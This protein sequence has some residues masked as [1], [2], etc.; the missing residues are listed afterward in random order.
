MSDTITV[1]PSEISPL[2][3]D[4]CNTVSPGQ[5]P[6]YVNVI[7]ESYCQ[8]NFCF[9]NVE[10]KVQIDGGSIVYGWQ[11]WLMPEILIE[12]EF[13]AVWKSPQGELID[14]IPRSQPVEKILFI[15]DLERTYTGK[16]VDN[17][18][19]NISDNELVDTFINIAKCEFNIVSYFETFKSRYFIPEMD[20]EIGKEL[21]EIH[22][23]YLGMIRNKMKRSDRCICGSG[24]KFKNCCEKGCLKIIRYVRD[25]YR[26]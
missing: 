21:I 2:V 1:V 22:R 13:H 11:I 6:Q 24:K 10:Q 9:P 25:N 26:N 8:E 5:T 17:I 3:M 16:K 20:I 23:I 18:R 12:A 4:F 14:I 7:P 15:Q 19:K